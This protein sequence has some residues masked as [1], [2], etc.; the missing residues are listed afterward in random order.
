MT[1]ALL[2]SLRDRIGREVG[3]SS[4]K[5]IDQWRISMFGDATGDDDPMHVDPAW[6]A[7]NSPFGSTISFGFLTM[8]LLTSFCQEVTHYEGTSRSDSCRLNYSFDRVR[9]MAPVPVRG[10]IRG[11]F[12]LED[13]E[14]RGDNGYL[15]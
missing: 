12:R 14:E 7:T 1:S 13:T 11:R 3:V 15:I 9:L 2:Q 8:S 6:S 10:R 4:W 5:Q